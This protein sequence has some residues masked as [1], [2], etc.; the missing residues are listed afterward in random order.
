[1]IEARL[2]LFHPI[3]PFYFGLFLN[4]EQSSSILQQA[5]IYFQQA[6]QWLPELRVDLEKISAS[7]SS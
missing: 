3:I 5:N 1:M 7:K 2:K 6:L 4:E